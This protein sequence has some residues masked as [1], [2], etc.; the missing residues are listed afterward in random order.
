MLVELKRSLWRLLNRPLFGTKVIPPNARVDPSLFSEED[1][2]VYCPKCDYPLRGLVDPRCPE[3]GEPFDRGRLLVLQ[4]VTGRTP[5]YK[6]LQKILSWSSTAAILLVFGLDFGGQYLL[7]RLLINFTT[8]SAPGDRFILIVRGMRF[9]QILLL[10]V[11][12]SE[13][14]VWIALYRANR[15]KRRQIIEQIHG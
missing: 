7:G 5:R 2:P 8:F 4:Y 13:G 12:L 3:C 14:V 9:V 15:Q 11:L 10:A 6:R 1:F